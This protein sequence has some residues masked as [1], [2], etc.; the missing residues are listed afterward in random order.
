MRELTVSPGLESVSRFAETFVTAEARGVLDV[1]FATA[2]SGPAV[3]AGC[4][5]VVNPS[6]CQT[7]AGHGVC[8]PRATRPCPAKSTE[9]GQT[10]WKA[11][12]Q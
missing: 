6:Q 8:D 10:S 7:L 4:P 5:V 9:T 12:G 2:A 1:F 11:L 3:M